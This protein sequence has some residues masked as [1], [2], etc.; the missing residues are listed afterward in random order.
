M[1]VKAIE[2][3]FNCWKPKSY[4]KA[5]SSEA[6]SRASIN[7]VK[8]MAWNKFTHKDFLIKFYKDE[9]N[10]DYEVVSEYVRMLDKVTVVHKKCGHEFTRL[11]SKSTPKVYCPKCYPSHRNKRTQ[12]MF[13]DEVEEITNGEY[14]VVGEYINVDSKIV[15]RHKTC[16]NSWF[17]NANSFL[18]GTRCPKCAK[19][20]TL[21]THEEFL[22][23]LQ[24]IDDY[25]VEY[26]FLSEYISYDKKIPIIHKSC[27]SEYIVSP[28]KFFGGRRCPVCRKSHGEEKINKFLKK[29]A[30]SFEREKKF[31]GLRYRY[32]LRFDFFIESPGYNSFLVEFDGRQHF[33][34]VWWNKKMTEKEVSRNFEEIQI[35][36]KMKNEFADKN[37]IPL[38][39]INYD[40]IKELDKIMTDILLKERSTTIE[41]VPELSQGVSK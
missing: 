27:G 23:R 29:N 32:P 9:W 1:S 21:L 3:F 25:G 38:Y 31:K 12:K 11:A 26:E 5:I 16:G 33:Q 22:D 13:E 36:D 18:S 7:E 2:N 6:F 8:F 28:N 35:K 24:D 37:K 40:R 17:V 4:D 34:L 10:K 41:S 19:G 20:G 30:V 15:I 39:R 14:K